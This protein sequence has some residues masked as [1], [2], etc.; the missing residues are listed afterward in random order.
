[1]DCIIKVRFDKVARNPVKAVF[2]I[3][4]LRFLMSDREQRP[5]VLTCWILKSQTNIQLFPSPDFIFFFL[6]GGLLWHP[7]NPL[8]LW[9]VYFLIIGRAEGSSFFVFPHVYQTRA[10]KLSH[11]RWRRSHRRGVCGWRAFRDDARSHTHTHTPAGWCYICF[12]FLTQLL[13]KRKCPNL[14]EIIRD[15]FDIFWNANAMKTSVTNSIMYLNATCSNLPLS[16]YE[17][18]NWWTQKECF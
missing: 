17:C 12:V 14:T 6:G 1:M 13:T 3:R 15:Y 11:Q 18:G 7:G 5:P 4:H 9:N 2:T 10:G 16:N 8:S